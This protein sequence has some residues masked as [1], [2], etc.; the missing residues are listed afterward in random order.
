LPATAPDDAEGDPPPDD[1]RA[2]SPDA[3]AGAHMVPE[4]ELETGTGFS[5]DSPL[6]AAGLARPR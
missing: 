2:Q 5:G 1:L 4:R 6:P 3:R